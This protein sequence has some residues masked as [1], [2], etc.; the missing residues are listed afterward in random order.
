VIATPLWR[1]VEGNQDHGRAVV[2]LGA[3]EQALIKQ[4]TAPVP[5]QPTVVPP[6]IRK[7]TNGP[8]VDGFLV[9]VALDDRVPQ[10]SLNVRSDT[11]PAF[12]TL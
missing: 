4:T 2:W 6:A 8:D 7:V 9:I 3:Y 1:A 11:L 12:I 5:P 10:G